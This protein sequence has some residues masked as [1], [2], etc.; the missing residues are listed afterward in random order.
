M[1]VGVSRVHPAL[2]TFS[3]LQNT[4]GAPG[5]LGNDNDPDWDVLH[6][7]SHAQPG[8]GTVAVETNGSFVYVPNLN[9]C[10][11]DGFS[12]I[13]DDGNGATDSATVSLA[14]ECVA[15]P[16]GEIFADDFETGD[17]T[18]WLTTVGDAP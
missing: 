1:G 4:P 6:V 13:A 2:G 7:E 11:D 14:I 17:T 16:P 5:V 10:G 12:Y 8:K 3:H 18:A 15:E 9:S